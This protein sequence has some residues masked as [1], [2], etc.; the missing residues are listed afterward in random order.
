MAIKTP[1]EIADYARKIRAGEFQDEEL[2]PVLIDITDTVNHLQA[3][4]ET[5]QRNMTEYA[6]KLKTAQDAN[7][8]YMAEVIALKG[9]PLDEEDSEDEP[10]KRERYKDIW[11]DDN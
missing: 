3:E 1:N 2:S 4:A 6:A 8:T 9:N 5:A 11:K 7:A 10:P